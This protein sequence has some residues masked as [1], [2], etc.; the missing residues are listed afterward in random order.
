MQEA[1]PQG[2]EKADKAYIYPFLFSL[3]PVL[4]LYSRNIREVLPIQ[5]LQALGISLAIAIAFWLLAGVVERS[6][7][8]RSLLLFLFLLLFHFYGLYYGQ[9]ATWLP[10]DSRPLLAHAIAFILPGGLWL[11]LSRAVVRSARNLAILNRVLQLAVIFLVLWNVTGILIYHGQSS[12]NRYQQQRRQGHELRKQLHDQPAKPDIYCF[13][14]DEFASLESARTL[15]QYDNSEF[16]ETL[17]QLGFFVA[18]DSRSRFQLTELAIADILNL[19]ELDEKKDPYLQIRKNVVASFLKQRGYRIIEIPLEPAMFMD[20]AD[21]R[22]YYSLVHISIFFDDFYRVL[23]ERSLLRFLPDRWRRQSPD[24]P[25]YFRERVLHVFEKLPEL[26]KSPGPKFIYVHLYCPH[27]PFVFDAQG[28]TEPADHFWDHADP[29]YYLQQYMF[30]SRKIAQIVTRI[31][32]DSPAPPVIIIQSDHG[33][34]G[35]RGR[36]KL[37][38]RVAWAEKVKVFNALYLPGIDIRQI[39]PSLAPRNNFRLIFSRYFAEPLPLFKNP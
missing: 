30:V 7:G 11:C 19:G 34:R 28:G 5:V 1:Q 22:F 3:Y 20:V 27:E 31:R 36:R 10:D 13:V 4:F 38:R 8:K 23:F 14:L 33:Y 17:R 9:I 16:A 35:S 24:A 39:E 15:F 25:R 21:Q 18:R 29:R 26:V 6:P 12:A 37:G 2:S 32:K